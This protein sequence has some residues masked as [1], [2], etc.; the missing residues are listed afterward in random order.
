MEGVAPTEPLSKDDRDNEGLN[1]SLPSIETILNRDEQILS[2]STF[3]ETT[4][5]T[6]DEASDEVVLDNFKPISSI[7][8]DLSLSIDPKL[9]EESDS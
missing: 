2:V 6:T 9:L 5:S 4:L 3:S 8:S 7:P 1:H